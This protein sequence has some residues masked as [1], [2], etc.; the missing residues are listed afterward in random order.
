MVIDILW[1]G[2]F[3]LPYNQIDS[4]EKTIVGLQIH[5]SINEIKPFVFIAG[6][7]NG[8]ILFKKIIQVIEDNNLNIKII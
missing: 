2:Q 4:M 3:V 6:I 5:H 8:S 7:G 1:Q